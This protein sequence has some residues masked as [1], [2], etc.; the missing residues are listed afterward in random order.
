ME[1]PALAPWLLVLAL[2]VYVGVPY[3]AVRTEDTGRTTAPATFALWFLAGYVGPPVAAFYIG[4]LLGAPL[5]A[6][7]VALAV[8]S[9]TVFVAFRHLVRRVR[10][11]GY[12]RTLAFL[13]VVPLVT[14]AC[15]VFLAT[16]PRVSRDDT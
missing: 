16:A 14:I 10:D 11:A 7:L 4:P 1:E 5:L 6:G 3:V 9:V 12:P 8:A 15:A 2:V 13:A